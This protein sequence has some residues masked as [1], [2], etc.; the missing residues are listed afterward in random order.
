M[1]KKKSYKANPDHYYDHPEMDFKKES[2]SIFFWICVA[3]AIGMFFAC[4]STPKY[5]CPD[6]RRAVGYGSYR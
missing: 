5:G 1:R 2:N 3:I 4:C 6:Q